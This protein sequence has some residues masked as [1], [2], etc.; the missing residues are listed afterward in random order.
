MPIT[1]TQLEQIAEIVRRRFRTFSYEALG[2]RALTPMELAQLQAAGVVRE[3]VRNL[4]FDS[5]LLGKL[6][7]LLP[8]SARREVTYD[9]VLS[10][11]EHLPMTPIE[12]AAVDY[13]TDHAGEYI[14]G[15]G[16][17][18]VR[19][20][21]AIT[22][23]ASDAAL[24]AVRENVVESISARETISELKTR[25]FDAI[26]NRTRDWQRVAHTEVNTAVQQGVYRTIREAS[27]DGKEQVVYKR[28]NPDAC[29]HC[30]RLFL[31]SDGVTPRVFRM[32]DLT[33]SN[34]GLPAAAW[35]PTIGS[36]HPWCNCQLQV[37]PEGYDFKTMR[38]CLVPFDFD[39]RSFRRGEVIDDETYASLD[40]TL[41]SHVGTDAVLS[42]TG[43]T[44][45][46][47]LEKSL[48]VSHV[49]DD[50]TCDHD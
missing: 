43:T 3:S 48:A 33:D 17:M 32:G 30:K 20:V 10:A 36:V 21:S 8:P 45:T 22:A 42:Y 46:P 31:R 37:I 2:P 7:A 40:E 47:D 18:M 34:V 27:D 50:C 15:I 12:Q 19:D 44:A 23:R 26:D 24:R 11:A 13:A 16:D 38:V 39:G 6:T 49:T 28:P 14:R 41:K 29:R 4:V 25:L 1:K 35:G 5:A 9:T